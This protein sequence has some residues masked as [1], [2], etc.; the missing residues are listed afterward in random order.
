MLFRFFELLALSLVGW[1]VSKL[2]GFSQGATIFGPI[3]GIAIWVVWD[4]VRATRVTTWLQSRRYDAPPQ[5]S[6]VWGDVVERSRK[7]FRRLIRRA[8]DR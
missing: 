1:I 3:A 5:V 7:A 6:G 4:G 8:Q 2:L